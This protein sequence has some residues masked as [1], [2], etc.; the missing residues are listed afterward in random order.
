MV[1]TKIKPESLLSFQVYLVHR[2]LALSTKV[3]GHSTGTKT[4]ASAAQRP[5]VRGFLQA[6]SAY[7]YVTVPSVTCLRQRLKLYL[8]TAQV[9]FLTRCYGQATAALR[10]G[11]SLQLQ[12]INPCLRNNN[13]FYSFVG[14]H[15]QCREWSPVQLLTLSQLERQ[16]LGGIPLERPCSQHIVISISCAGRSQV[17]RTLEQEFQ[18][19]YVSK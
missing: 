2:V 6:C 11:C 14:G 18:I 5:R 3:L 8:A 10:G 17:G 12:L 19:L 1:R 7:C 15:P 4:A 9:G 13:T 16:Q